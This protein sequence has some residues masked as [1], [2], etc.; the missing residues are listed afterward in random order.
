MPITDWQQRVVDE[1][2]ELKDK[3]DKLRAYRASPEYLKLDTVNS[4]C[5]EWQQR[6]MAEYLAILARRIDLFTPDI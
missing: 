4:K 3:L 2:R 5:L 1:H 6:A